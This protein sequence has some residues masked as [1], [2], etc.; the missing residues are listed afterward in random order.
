MTVTVVPL[1][2]ASENVPLLRS[3]IL[4]IAHR[5]RRFIG[6]LYR[7]LSGFR[8]TTRIGVFSDDN[9]DHEFESLGTTVPSQASLDAGFSVKYLNLHDKN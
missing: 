6:R 1:D 8:I 4:S 2:E 9:A 3:P 7:P 5:S